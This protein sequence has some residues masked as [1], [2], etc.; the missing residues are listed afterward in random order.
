MKAF[1]T[2]FRDDPKFPA[3]LKHIQDPPQKID[4]LGEILPEDELSVAVVGTRNFTSYGQEVVEKI[5]PVLSR[6]GLTVV[7]GMARGIDTLA[8]E[9]AL[10]CGGR[11]IAVWGTG[12]NILYPPESK[13]LFE[14]IVKNGAVISEFDSEQE[15]TNWT[16]PTRNRIISGLSLGVL[17]VEAAEKSGA[18]IT[19]SLAAKQGR[20]V[21]AVPSSIF[22]PAGFGPNLLIREGAHPITC[23][24]EILEILEVEIKT[25][26]VQAKKVLPETQEEE[27]LM[28]IL[29]S[30]PTHI[31]DLVRKSGFSVSTVGS[32]LVVMELRGLIKNMG[33]QE[34]REL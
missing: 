27:L 23:A 9:A 13:N 7:S 12:I 4:V 11:T 15:P 28:K 21:F 34:Y 1:K 8:H 17:V 14:R 16:F 20:E 26:K 24:E 18:L 6:S 19:A 2:I 22:S 3:R 10:E 29:K 32:T 25:Q 33:N 30:G 31:D 5:V